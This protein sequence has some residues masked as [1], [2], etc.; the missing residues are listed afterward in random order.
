[1]RQRRGQFLHLFVT[2][3][4]PRD[5]A[6][7]DHARIQRVRRDITI[8]AARVYWPPIMEIQRAVTAAAWRGYRIAV[9]LR[10]VHPV[11]KL[12]IRHH[13]IELPSG[14]V[15]PGTPSLTAVARYN[16]SL[17]AA[18]NHSPRLVGI[19]P[20]L[21]VI[22]AP[23]R[24]FESCKRLPSIAR[25]VRCG[26]GDVHRIGIFGIHA[27]FSEVPPALPDAPVIR[28]ALPTLPAVVRSIEPALLGIH[29]QINPPRIARRKSDA[30][31]SETLRWF[32][33]PAHIFP[34]NA[35]IARARKTAA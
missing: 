4:L 6:A 16:R 11:R 28:N 9:L 17:V 7:K 5:R 13:M 24:T 33:L 32:C 2:E 8:F 26:I 21:V 35:S 23:G 15:E 22:V 18:E 10:A 1:M 19:N 20:Q 29:D 12:V 31:P 14:L 34:M 3:I 27:D 25:L 30:D